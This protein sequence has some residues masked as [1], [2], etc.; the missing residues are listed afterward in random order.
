MTEIGTAIEEIPAPAP[1]AFGAAVVDG[2]RPVVIRGLVR[3]WPVVVAAL[4]GVA[5]LRDILRGAARDAMVETVVGA[6]SIRGRFFYRPDFSGFNFERSR[7]SMVSSIDTIFAEA[8]VAEPRSLA[9]QA[10]SL[11]DYFPGLVSTHPLPFV[12]AGAVPRVW[13]GN[14]V[15]V[16][17]HYDPSD[18]LACVVAGRRR[19]T[20][21]PPTAICDLYPG[22][23]D[24]TPAG[25][26]VSLA[27][28]DAGTD[29]AFPRMVQAR[30][31]AQSAELAPGDAIFIPFGWWHHVQS[32]DKVSMLINYWWNGAPA[33]LGSPFLALVHAI[34]SVRALPASQRDVWKTL[35]DQYVFE[36]GGSATAHIPSARLGLLGEMTP[37]MA[38]QLREALLRRLSQGD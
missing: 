22:P 20:L 28:I 18:N 13:L 24:F 27:P 26:P 38:R 10:A 31:V 6:P 15:T 34:M 30:A 21:F 29:S 8:D 1:E 25:S 11:P 36:A 3:A 5:A 37:A 4:S 9:I 16:Q 23:L 35:F 32:L 14:Q 12:P 33:H 2:Q 17:T 7:A 19:F